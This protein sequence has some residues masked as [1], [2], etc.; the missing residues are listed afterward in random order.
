MN[1]SLGVLNVLPPSS[2]RGT[3]SVEPFF[4]ELDAICTEARLWFDHGSSSRCSEKGLRS[5]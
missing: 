1:W 2:S 3:R 5:L 4:E